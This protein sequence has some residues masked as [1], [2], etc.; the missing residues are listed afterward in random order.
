MSDFDYGYDTLRGA[1]ARLVQTRAQNIIEDV[2][3]DDGDTADVEV[4]IEDVVRIMDED[5]RTYDRMLE[6]MD[7]YFDDWATKVAEDL[8]FVQ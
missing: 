1:L 2:A 3:E 8:G 6:M 7:S 5:G 4:L